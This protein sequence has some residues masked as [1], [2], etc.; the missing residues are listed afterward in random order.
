M[1]INPQSAS[2]TLRHKSPKNGPRARYD[3]PKSVRTA[4]G[5]MRNMHKSLLITGNLH[6]E[7][8]YKKILVDLL[9]SLER[10]CHLRVGGVSAVLFATGQ[11]AEF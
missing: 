1:K 5:E 9:N 3:P 8:C 6:F 10:G 2:K 11:I 7:L 4:R